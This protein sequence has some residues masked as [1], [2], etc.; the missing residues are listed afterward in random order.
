MKGD[1]DHVQDAGM[2]VR[3]GVWSFYSGKKE[4]ER[5]LMGKEIREFLKEFGYILTEENDG[6]ACEPCPDLDRVFGRLAER[7][8]EA[9]RRNLC[10]PHE[11]G[12]FLDYPI[13]DVRGF[14][15]NGGQEC[16]LAGY[17]KVYHNRERA[18]MTFL[19]YDQAKTSAVNEFLTGKSIQD[20]VY[21]PEFHAA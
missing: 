4:M 13:E 14:I 21:R 15:E 7:I 11:I 10:F 1:R 3:S 12:V 16:L 20:I 2:S 19:A 8:G 5:Y 6:H 17:W 9:S 18:Q